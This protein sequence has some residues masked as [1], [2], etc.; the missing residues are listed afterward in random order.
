[1]VGTDLQC[2]D[3][4]CAGRPVLRNRTPRAGVNF[5]KQKFR[6]KFAAEQHV[7]RHFAAQL[8]YCT[9][10]FLNDDSPEVVRD[11]HRFPAND[12]MLFDPWQ[13][14]LECKKYHWVAGSSFQRMNNLMHLD[15][16][17]IAGQDKSAD[18]DPAA[19][20]AMMRERLRQKALIRLPLRHTQALHP[21]LFDSQ[22]GGAGG[23]KVANRGLRLF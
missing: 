21:F 10:Q 15:W 5:F 9:P 6:A 14:G 4:Q 17:H 8:G 19:L 1:M 12:V 20:Q 23:R 11:Y 13:I 16:L 18:G 7:C 22:R 2:A 3:L